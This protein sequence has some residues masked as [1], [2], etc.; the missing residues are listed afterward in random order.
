MRLALSRKFESY[1]SN[2]FEGIRRVSIYISSSNPYLLDVKF[3]VHSVSLPQSCIKIFTSTTG[4]FDFEELEKQIE[5][6]KTS[7][8]I[9]LLLLADLGS[10]LSG[11]IDG[12]LKV[13]SELS[14][15]HEMWLHVSGSLIA[16]LAVAQNQPEITRSV[17][18]MVLEVESWLGLP[19]TPTVLLY[20]PFTMLN[21]SVFEIESDMGKIEAFPLW[22]VLQNVGRDRIVTA[23]IQAFQ[24]C[25]V[26]YETISKIKGFKLL[27]KAPLADSKEPSNVTVVLFQF[28]GSNVEDIEASEGKVPAKIIDK[29]LNTLY[30]S[31]LNSWLFQTL[32]RD[33]P[34]VQLT[35]LDHPTHGTCIRYSPFELSMGEKVRL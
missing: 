1:I 29:D 35:L 26:I 33:F 28:D 19:T 21:Q 32:E 4:S 6:D 7:S 31:R 17:S 5:A 27:S 13:L 14:N 24:S 9:P 15:K 22:T 10:S 30:Y 18:S 25:R 23:I 34:Q 3:A 11:D 20:K 8:T 16:S 2:G 12:S